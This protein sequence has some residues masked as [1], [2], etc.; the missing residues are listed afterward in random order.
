MF[1]SQRKGHPNAAT[2]RT[3]YTT[4]RSQSTY[5]SIQIITVRFYARREISSCTQ[6]G[7]TKCRVVHLRSLIVDFRKRKIMQTLKS[8]EDMHFITEDQFPETMTNIIRA[9]PDLCIGG[10]TDRP[11]DIGRFLLTRKE[12]HRDFCACISFLKD[13]IP[14][15][16]QPISTEAMC[17]KIRAY[18][19]LPE[20]DE[21]TLIAAAIHLKCQLFRQSSTGVILPPRKKELP[22]GNIF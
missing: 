11:T 20:L 14:S 1:L 12:L 7:R 2:Y 18:L 5:R 6:I 16:K 13:F 21:G 17:R 4:P 22:D 19:R 9:H 15:W 3:N 8:K 10:F